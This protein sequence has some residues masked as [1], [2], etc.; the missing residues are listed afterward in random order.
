MTSQTGD[1]CQ[2]NDPN[3]LFPIEALRFPLDSSMRIVF[4]G[5]YNGFN[6][7]VRSI[8]EVALLYHMGCFGK[9]SM[10][11]SK[12]KLAQ[13]D[14][15]PSIMRKRQFVK[16]NYWYKKFV[17]PR[18]KSDG[19]EFLKD[20]DALS[21]KLISDCE[22][23]L[24]KEVIDLVSSDD[25]LSEPNEDLDNPGKSHSNDKGDVVVIV[26]NSDSEEDD[27]FANLKP[28]CCLNKT[29]MQ[30]KL[31]LTLQEAFFLLYGLGCLQIVSRDNKLSNVHQCWDL[32]TAADKN[33]IPKYVVYHYYRS[34]GYVV[35]PGIKFGGDYCKNL[36]DV[37]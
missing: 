33:F 13:S 11:R 31:I 7:E 1:D 17:D 20:I 27:Y 21:A 23:Q 22:K 32:F 18:K 25:D 9:G 35:K 14:G 19:D 30:E 16:R 34:K 5:Y 12:P 8:E 37:N 4:T 26:P 2:S 3:N 10:S 28:K 15:S 6:V 24:N 29:K 36:C